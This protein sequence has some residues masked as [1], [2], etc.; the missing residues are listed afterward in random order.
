VTEDRADVRTLGALLSE[1]RVI[2]PLHAAT[3]SDALRLLAA[4]AVADGL[5]DR[6][7][8]EQELETLTE[9]DLIPI[10]SHALMAHLRTEHAR[11]LTAMMGIAE[12]PL[13]FAPAT[14]PTART[15]ILVIAPPATGQRYL[16][17]MAALARLLGRGDVEE[18]LAASRSAGDVLDMDALQEPILGTEILVRD[19]M[20]RDIVSVTADAPMAYVAELLIRR[21]LRAI[22]VTGPNGEIVGMVTDADVMEMFLPRIRGEDQTS[23]AE[24]RSLPDRSVREAMQRSFFTARDDETIEAVADRMI[25]KDIGRLPVVTEGRLVGFLT[26]GDIVRRLLRGH[27]K[28]R[29]EQRG[30]SR[31]SQP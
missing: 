16:Q 6:D 2:L 5:A 14:A 4:G 7:R 1:Q 28:A 19:L 22:P 8:L 31:E 10:G 9:Q 13:P 24:A 23:S 11:E 15:L 20:T 17:T 30:R 21:R 29:G 25:R 3:L 26:R 12:G 27:L 18:R